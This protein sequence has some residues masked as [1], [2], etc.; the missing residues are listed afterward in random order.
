MRKKIVAGNW[1]MN[2]T[3]DEASRLASEIASQAEELSEDVDIV[4]IPPFTNLAAVC[5]VLKQTSVAVGAQNLHW[6]RSGA[7]TGEISAEMIASCGARYVVIGHSERRQLFGETDESVFKKL[8]AA[9]EAG[10]FPI[11][12]VGETLDERNRENTFRVVEK[13]LRGAFEDLSKDEF[14]RVVIAY[15][16]VWAIGTGL[17]ATPEQA[18]E[19]HKYIRNLVVELSDEACGQNIRIQYGGSVK[20]ENAA[21]LMSQPDVDGA[22][23]G[24]ASLNGDSF[25]RII[26][27]AIH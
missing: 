20:P 26:K 17:N 5:A 18:Q 1:K 6:E 24:G 22:L 10:L 7:Y 19:V 3:L 4:L 25:Y 15:E 8:K 14:H 23:V 2:T 16:P 27:A 13:Q 9:L 21:E 11:V 12:C